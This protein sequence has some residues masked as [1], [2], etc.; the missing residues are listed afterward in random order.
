MVS[1][2]PQEILTWQRLLGLQLNLVPLAAKS[3]APEKPFFSPRHRD[4]PMVS[5]HCA[6]GVCFLLT[7]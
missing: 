5:Q 6:S 2:S 3:F 4:R 7:C 1:F